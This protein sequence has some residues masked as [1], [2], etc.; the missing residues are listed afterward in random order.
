VGGTPAAASRSSDDHTLHA[1]IAGV[2]ARHGHDVV[3]TTGRHDRHAHQGWVANFLD[4]PG[5]NQFYAYVTTLVSNAHHCGV[6]GGN[7]GVDQPTLRSR[8]RLPS[9]GK[10]G[11]CYAPPPAR[12][13]FGDVPCPS[14]F[15]DWIE[16]LA[17]RGHRGG[18][19]N[20]NFCPPTRCGETRWRR[21]S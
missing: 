1:T 4:V 18:C 9:K 11:L 8:W 15:A 21:F 5:A 14:T 2:R 3:T 20:G 16:A 13:R 6:G 7:Y 12:A 19:G 17:V 10:H